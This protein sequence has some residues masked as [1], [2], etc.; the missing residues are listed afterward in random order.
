MTSKQKGV[1]LALYKGDKPPTRRN[2]VIAPLCQADLVR[3]TEVT[4]RGSCRKM[5][6]TDWGRIV[7]AELEENNMFGY[8]CEECGKGTVRAKKFKNYKTK[9]KKKPFTV[10][11]ATI[12]VCNNCGGQHFSAKEYKR[13][14]ALF[15]RSRR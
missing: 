15:E 5:E 13:W 1:L 6:L 12:G 4:P 10:P 9:F 7:A 8:K 2:D 11:S 3:V 14:R